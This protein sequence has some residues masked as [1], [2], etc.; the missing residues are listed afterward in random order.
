MSKRSEVVKIFE[1]AAREAGKL[2]NKEFGKVT[3]SKVQSK[4]QSLSQKRIKCTL[5][6]KKPSASQAP[7]C[8]PTRMR[9]SHRSRHSVEHNHISLQTAQSDVLRGWNQKDA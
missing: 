6:T 3:E 4:V 7:Q 5:S 8:T 1:S 9:C 2:I